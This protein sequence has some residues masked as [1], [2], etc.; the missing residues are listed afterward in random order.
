MILSSTVLLLL[1][2]SYHCRARLIPHVLRNQDQ[3]RRASHTAAF[4]DSLLQQTSVSGGVP[5]VGA[6]K[7]PS[8]VDID[9]DDS[10]NLEADVLAVMAALIESD[11]AAVNWD[12][13]RV[14]IDDEETERMT[15]A[16]VIDTPFETDGSLPQDLDPPDDAV[17]SR[18]PEDILDPPNGVDELSESSSSE[19]FGSEGAEIPAMEPI[20]PEYIVDQAYV[21]DETSRGSS[22]QFSGMDEA[23]IPAMEPIPPEY[24]VGQTHIVNESVQESLPESSD[25]ETELTPELDQEA[26]IPA[27]EPIPPEREVPFALAYNNAAESAVLNETSSVCAGSLA[28]AQFNCVELPICKFSVGEN[29]ITNVML[30]DQGECSRRCDSPILGDHHCAPN[31]QCYHFVFGCA[32]P[33]LAT[34]GGECQP[35]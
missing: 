2:S 23:E 18:L 30:P 34:D 31:Q 14:L 26:E 4:D 16:D 32:C 5:R 11:T 33:K 10:G 35:Y 21:A 12:Q 9:G 13:A 28:E 20:P 29:G 22:S 25:T 3:D 17:F 19:L 1:C 15:G 6:H 24:I 8:D 7:R 27:M